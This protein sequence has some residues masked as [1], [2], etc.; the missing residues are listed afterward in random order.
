MLAAGAVGLETVSRA[1]DGTFHHGVVLIDAVPAHA[2]AA[3]QLVRAAA[4]NGLAAGE[5]D[6]AVMLEA[7]AVIR[8]KRVAPGAKPK[9]VGVPKSPQGARA[10][11]RPRRSAG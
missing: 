9:G 11:V 1:G 6:D 5:G 4:I 8:E 2:N 7:R 10:S 3:Q